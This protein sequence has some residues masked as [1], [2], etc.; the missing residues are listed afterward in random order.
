LSREW[1]LRATTTVQDTPPLSAI[2]QTILG[3][4]VSVQGESP[5]TPD[6]SGTTHN[7]SRQ[8]WDPH[9]GTRHFSLEES[10]SSSLGPIHWEEEGGEKE[11][12]EEEQKWVLVSSVFSLL[13][14]ARDQRGK[15]A[16][17]RAQ[18]KDGLPKEEEEET[19]AE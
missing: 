15:E 9:L 13:L 1:R 11:E 4:K 17:Q 2:D 14:F 6:R 10:K 16:K 12:E 18:T 7:P 3:S 5:Q 8:C 19:P